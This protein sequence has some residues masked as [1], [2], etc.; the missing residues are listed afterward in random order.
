MFAALCKITGHTISFQTNKDFIA[1][2]I[3][4]EVKSFHDKPTLEDMKLHNKYLQK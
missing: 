2:Q 3:D 1:N 4:A